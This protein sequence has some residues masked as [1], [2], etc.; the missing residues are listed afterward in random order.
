LY[1][2]AYRQFG[3]DRR[4]YSYGAS[5]LEQIGDRVQLIRDDFAL[6]REAFLEAS[7]SLESL[8]DRLLRDWAPGARMYAIAVAYLLSSQINAGEVGRL[9]GSNPNPMSQEFANYFIKTRIGGTK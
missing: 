9:L 6:A 2:L 7:S 3:K 1:D 5:E 8:K 4:P